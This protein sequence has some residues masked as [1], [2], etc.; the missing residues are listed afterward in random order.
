MAEPGP[1]QEPG[2]SP[3]PSPGQGQGPGSDVKKCG[4]LRKWK[5]LH[6]RYCVLRSA[7]DSGPARLELY[8]S[9][10]K[11]RSR[12]AGPRRAL[13]LSS[14][15]TVNKRRD[16]RSRYLLCVYTRSES[17]CLAAAGAEEQESWYRALSAQ[18]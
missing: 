3:S 1:E 11:F 15:F 6:R 5:S 8:D 14:C 9:E 18:L 10:K 7:S 2:Q 12:G 16:A 13:P 17:V 4:V